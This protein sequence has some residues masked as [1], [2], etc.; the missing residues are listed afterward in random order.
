MKLT[1]VTTKFSNFQLIFII[2]FPICTPEIYTLFQIWPMPIELTN[3][4]FMFIQPNNPYL[5]ISSDNQHFISYSDIEYNKCLTLGVSIKYCALDMPVYLGSYPL[6]EIQLLKLT[7]NTI[8]PKQ[9][10]VHHIYHNNTYFEKLKT[11]NTF[12]Y[13]V[14]TEIQTTL[15]CST[16]TTFHILK[17]TGTIRLPDSCSL[18]T[19]TVILK[20]SREE[21]KNINI[22]VN[23]N[24]E[25]S[26]L[27]VSELGLKIDKIKNSKTNLK[28]I[29]FQMP[30][31]KNLHQSAQKLDDI[32]DDI[33]KELENVITNNYQDL[34]I[35]RLY[36]IGGIVGYL[37]MHT[38]ISKIK[39]YCR[40]EREREP[41]EMVGTRGRGRHGNNII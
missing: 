38:I 21:I 33:D 27:D 3:L 29:N 20:S 5:A 24:P 19:P 22:S 13:W 4:Q 39:L 37:V 31:L 12:L 35:Y 30:E 10:T 26:L 15:V 16:S 18:Y 40:G 8:L 41:R 11:K 23:I 28:K 36:L 1:K 2:N 14:A 17:G 7:N 34:H 6:C 25:I 9:C 32:L